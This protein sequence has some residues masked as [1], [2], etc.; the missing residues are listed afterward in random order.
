[1]ECDAHTNRALAFVLSRRIIVWVT[2]WIVIPQFLKGQHLQFHYL[3]RAGCR[4]GSNHG[5]LVWHCQF[6]CC[7]ARASS[8]QNTVYL[9]GTSV[10]TCLVREPAGNSTA[11]R[12]CAP[13]MRTNLAT[14]AA[15]PAHTTA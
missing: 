4:V 5:R 3:D 6:P 15:G 11:I 1:M 13:V 8:P 7:F 14:L 2:R 12:T 9:P 10:S